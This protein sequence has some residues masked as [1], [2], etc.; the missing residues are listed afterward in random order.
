MIERQKSNLRFF[1]LQQLSV[2]LIAFLLSAGASASAIAEPR[3]NLMASLKLDHLSLTVVLTPKFVSLLALSNIDGDKI[4]EAL[5]NPLRVGKGPWGFG[6]FSRKPD[7]ETRI[8]VDQKS[9]R[10]R[11]DASMATIWRLR[12]DLNE[13]GQ[14]VIVLVRPRGKDNEKVEATV[15]IPTSKFLPQLLSD[16]RLGR[17]LAAVILDQ[18]PF[19]SK[20]TTELGGASSRVTP[21]VESD[22][23]EPFKIPTHTEPLIPIAVELDPATGNF[24]VSANNISVENLSE[25]NNIWLFTKKRGHMVGELSSQIAKA[26]ELLGR[27]KQNKLERSLNASNIKGRSER[28]EAKAVRPFWKR[29]EAVAEIRGR[30]SVYGTQDNAIGLEGDLLLT[31]S[32]FVNL[33]VSTQFLRAKLQYQIP[34]S[35]PSIG[36]NIVGDGLRTSF[37]GAIGPGARVSLK[38]DHT[39]FF[40]PRL[41]FGLV[42]WRIEKLPI[43]LRATQVGFKFRECLLPG[44]GAVIG[45]QSPEALKVQWQ[46]RI[47]GTGM[48]SAGFSSLFADVVSS[49]RSPLK[50]SSGRGEIF[51]F[52][53]YEG[54]QLT[55]TDGKIDVVKEFSLRTKDF[56]FGGGYR[57]LWL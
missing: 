1:C 23:Q 29:L 20:L 14:A 55:K 2:P 57:W 26:T 36:G 33:W 44:V 49:W 17:L 37:I 51:A 35:D 56:A 9:T 10:E 34:S 24:K 46:A 25:Q 7:C 11:Y 42:E 16:L 40:Y 39:V 52:G 45:Y 54:S 22:A 30:A 28:R 8:P 12:V 4:C 43:Q 6:L 53:L 18:V 41:E 19:R 50:F 15:T 13:T 5:G 32:S 3:D 27:E 21:I 47:G 48:N 31:E 38:S